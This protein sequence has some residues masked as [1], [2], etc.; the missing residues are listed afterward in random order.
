MRKTAN[1]YSV[2]EFCILIG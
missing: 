1:E 2:S